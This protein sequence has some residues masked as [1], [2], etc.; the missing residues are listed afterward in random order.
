MGEVAAAAEDELTSW[1]R[2]V[3]RGLLPWIL[4]DQA[5]YVLTRTRDNL[6]ALHSARILPLIRGILSHPPPAPLPG[7]YRL[8]RTYM[9]I[10]TS[11]STPTLPRLPFFEKAV[12]AA[13]AT[14]SKPAIIDTRTGREH[15]YSD[16]LRDAH[17]FRGSL[18]GAEEHAEDLKEARVAALIPNGC[19]CGWETDMGYTHCEARAFCM[20]SLHADPSDSPCRPPIPQTPGSSP[21]GLPG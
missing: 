4:H 10:A 18:V 2:R 3:G 21:S 12:R 9:M 7:P 6:L 1:G 8:R 17:A 19:E 5:S 20:Y 11:T 14:P 15:T 13:R 16:L